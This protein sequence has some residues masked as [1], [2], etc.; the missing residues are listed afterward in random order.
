METLDNKLPTTLYHQLKQI[1]L[2]K[3][4]SKEWHAGDKIPNEFELC[5]QY[6]VSRITVRQA[7][8]GLER[9]GYL[10]RR[11]G[12]GTFVTVPRIE[13]NLTTFYSFTE[14][15][16]KKG[17]IPWS[18]VLKFDLIK[19]GKDV[20]AELG[21]VEGVSQVYCITR[22]RYADEIAVAFETSWLP[23]DMFSGLNEQQLSGKPL[24]DIM[25]DSYHVILETAKES[26]GAALATEAEAKQLCIEKGEAVL[27]IQRHAFS[28][29]RCVEFT[30]GK[31]RAD[32][33]RFTARL[34]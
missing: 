10:I 17:F 34:T 33:F 23:A 12:K 6:K 21:D 3:I 7:L 2:G 18:K 1:L 15:F 20:L 9:E 29:S 13:Q 30:H 24:Y 28:G 14:E 22:L 27:D 8:A 5:K 32:M 4:L 19:A 31:I 26:I 25:R 16:K 11:Q